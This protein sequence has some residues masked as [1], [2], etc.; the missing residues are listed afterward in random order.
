MDFTTS[1]GT[2]LAKYAGGKALD[3]ALECRCRIL[4]KNWQEHF[5]G[6]LVKVNCRIHGRSDLS[7]K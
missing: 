7:N 5:S 1:I 6:K 3:T 4:P 2:W